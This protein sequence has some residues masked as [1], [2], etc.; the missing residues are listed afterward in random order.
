VTCT[1]TGILFDF[2]SE[3]NQANNKKKEKIH[4]I[5]SGIVMIKQLASNADLYLITECQSDS[6]EEE[7]CQQLEDLGV[8]D[9]GL[10]RHK[11]LF[12]SVEKGRVAI[13]R[14]IGSY[15]HIDHSDLVL[16]SLAKFIPHILR[17]SDFSILT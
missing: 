4:V 11:A 16:S 6:M 10:E 7:V 13:V 14:Q 8:F 3:T 17:S 12:S 15:L 9:V 1:T 2:N 5:E